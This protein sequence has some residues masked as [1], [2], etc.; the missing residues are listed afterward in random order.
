MDLF[1]EMG[2]W[3]KEL[4][5]KL[6]HHKK[7][8]VYMLKFEHVSKKYANGFEAVK[9]INFEVESGEISEQI[10]RAHV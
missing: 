7:R 6:T 9:D 3:V 5:S 8:G 2:Q 4:P 1:G 10:G